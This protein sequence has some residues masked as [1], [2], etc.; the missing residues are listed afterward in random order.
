M[1]PYAA[2]KGEL[3]E[4]MTALG[5]EH[6]VIIR[7]GFILGERPESRWMESAA[8][9][10][11]GFMPRFAKNKIGQDKEVIARAAVAAGLQAHAGEVK[12]MVWI[13][14]GDDILR[15]GQAEWKA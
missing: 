9:S 7:P 14:G 13:L 6:L 2:M 5:F 4:K 3:E 8:K 15:L 11:I 1:L 10:I 12:D